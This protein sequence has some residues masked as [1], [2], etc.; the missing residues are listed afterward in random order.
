MATIHF[1]DGPFEVRIAGV[2][3]G[4]LS[5]EARERRA[6]GAVVVRQAQVSIQIAC[7]SLLQAVEEA[8]ALGDAAGDGSTVGLRSSLPGLRRRMELHS[9]S[10]KGDA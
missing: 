1:F 7:A 3:N 5:F 4:V 9:R 10:E 2:A 6:A 8:L